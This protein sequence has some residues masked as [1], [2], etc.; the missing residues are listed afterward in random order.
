[1]I[2]TISFKLGAG[3]QDLTLRG[4]KARSATGNAWANAIVG[5]EGDNRIAAVM[6]STNLMRQSPVILLAL[7]LD[8]SP[9]DHLDVPPDGRTTHR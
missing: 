2:G 9:G 4:A 7:H 6:D 8:G 3:L 5:N 1:M